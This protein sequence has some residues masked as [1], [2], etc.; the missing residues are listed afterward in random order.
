M[1]TLDKKKL[2]SCLLSFQELFALFCRIVRYLKYTLYAMYN[3]VKNY[4]TWTCYT[5]YTRISKQILAI[6]LNSQSMVYWLLDHTFKEQFKPHTPC[7]I[8]L[9]QNSFTRKQITPKTVN[10][11]II[12]NKPVVFLAPDFQG[13][14]VTT[15]P[16]F[17]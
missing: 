6:C 4:N 13:S 11:I 9:I 16:S 8:G 3:N 1:T 7:Y 15:L 2:S 14:G 12:I 17:F 5:V 10:N